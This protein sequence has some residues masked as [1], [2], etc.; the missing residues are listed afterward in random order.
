MAKREEVTHLFEVREEFSET[1]DRV[2][3]EDRDDK[4]HVTLWKN[5]VGSMF[6][7][8]DNALNYL[9]INCVEVRRIGVTESTVEIFDEPQQ[10]HVASRFGYCN[11]DCPEAN[12]GNC[13]HPEECQFV[14]LN[15][16]HL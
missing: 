2:C 10:I 4:N 7:N 16:L 8:Y 12:L 11:A 9:K 14:P 15:K 1:F 13:C 3:I 6:E 5:S